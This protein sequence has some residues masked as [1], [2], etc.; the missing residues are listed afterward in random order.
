MKTSLNL[1]DELFTAA[2]KESLRSKRNLS[3]VI[4]YW[5]RLGRECDSAKKDA[6]RPKFSPVDLGGTAQ[7]DLANRRDWLDVLDHDRS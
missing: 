1:D 2:K 7:I 3:E 4:S 5:A 6:N